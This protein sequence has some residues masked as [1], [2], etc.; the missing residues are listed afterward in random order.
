MTLQVFILAVLLISL[1]FKCPCEVFIQGRLLN[2]TVLHRAGEPDG[3][4]IWFAN[5]YQ[6][7]HSSRF[8]HPDEA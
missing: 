2:D 1:F 4:E 3:R 7:Q 5:A 8:L 6:L